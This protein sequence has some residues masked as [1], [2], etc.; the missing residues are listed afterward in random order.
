MSI[1]YHSQQQQAVKLQIA[2]AALALPAD[3]HLKQDIYKAL[4]SNTS[5]LSED[6]RRAAPTACSCILP[7]GQPGRQCQSRD[8]H[9]PQAARR[10][11]QSRRLSQCLVCPGLQL[12]QHGK[13]KPPLYATL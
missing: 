9:C 8:S 13:T 4:V 12:K 10:Q 2:Q 6:R 7:V 11:C 5:T 1:I 3:I